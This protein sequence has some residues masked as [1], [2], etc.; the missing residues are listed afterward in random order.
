MTSILSLAGVL[1]ADIED[2]ISWFQT[3]G[4][5]ARHKNCP[6]CNQAMTQ[7]SRNDIIDMYR[8]CRRNDYYEAAL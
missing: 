2:Q 3:R 8:Y 6:S 4:L 7:Q 5:L 1:G